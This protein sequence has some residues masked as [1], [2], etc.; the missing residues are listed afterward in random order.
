MLRL[1]SL[2]T[3]LYGLVKNDLKSGLLKRTHQGSFLPESFTHISRYLDNDNIAPAS[4]IR[5]K[6]AI[7]T[8]LSPSRRE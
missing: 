2:F 7:F 5:E 1:L 4:I 6:T 3:V 8:Q